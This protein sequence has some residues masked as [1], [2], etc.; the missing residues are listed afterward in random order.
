MRNRNGHCLKTYKEKNGD[1]KYP[2]NVFFLVGL[3]P[4]SAAH[5]TM[6]SRLEHSITSFCFLNG[7][8]LNPRP[9]GHESSA[10]FTKPR[11]LAL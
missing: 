2:N 6:P 4:W 3:W 5:A 9:F 1:W 11:L 8:G 7:G 10:L